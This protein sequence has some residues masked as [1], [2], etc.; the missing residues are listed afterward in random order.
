MTKAQEI[1]DLIRRARTYIAHMA[2]HQKDREQGRLLIEL[3]EEL[4]E[5]VKRDQVLREERQ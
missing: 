3:Y 4:A 1:N 2:P 5:R